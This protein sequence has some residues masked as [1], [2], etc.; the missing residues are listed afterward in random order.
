MPKKTVVLLDEDV[1]EVLINESISK[2][3]TTRKMSKVLNELIRKAIKLEG[4]LE[5]KK[6][7]SEKK[8]AKVTVD[9]FH[10]FRKELSKRFES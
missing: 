1:Y 2:Y 3:G 4:I 7:L 5:I 10:R 8:K 6:I 9:K